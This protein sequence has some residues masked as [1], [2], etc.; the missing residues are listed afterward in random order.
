MSKSRHYFTGEL[1]Y[2]ALGEGRFAPH[3]NRPSYALAAAA[4]G[5]GDSGFPY[6]LREYDDRDQL[7][8]EW[9]FERIIPIT[10]VT[11]PLAEED[12]P[13]RW[14]YLNKTIPAAKCIRWCAWPLDDEG[15]V[16]PEDQW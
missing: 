7:V 12:H 8:A 9:T 6:V 14:A 15:R 13:N 4:A 2:H 11:H 1:L 3:L 16:L 10:Y 5:A